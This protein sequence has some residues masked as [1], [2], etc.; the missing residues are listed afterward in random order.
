MGIYD[1][2][3]GQPVGPDVP[4]LQCDTCGREAGSCVCPECLSCGAQAWRLIGSV[5][6]TGEALFECEC[7]ERRSGSLVLLVNPI[8]GI[9]S[10]SPAMVDEPTAL[11]VA[12]QEA[13]GYEHA[14]SGVYGSASQAIAAERGAALIVFLIAETDGLIPVL[15]G[16]VSARES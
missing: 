6:C 10:G 5:P 15:R 13:E 8:S 11:H 1:T 12:E 7:G 3:G 2:R 4:D 14:L 9:S 16:G